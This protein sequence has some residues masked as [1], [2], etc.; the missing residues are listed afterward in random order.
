LWCANRSSHCC[1]NRAVDLSELLSW[2]SDDAVDVSVTNLGNVGASGDRS[3]TPMATATYQLSAKGPGGEATQTAT[4]NVGTQP[5]ATLAASQQEVHYYKI[6]NKVVQDDPITLNWSA[7]NADKVTITA[8][9]DQGTNG[10]ATVTSEPVQVTT[11]NVD[12]TVNYTLSASNACGGTITKTAA[13]HVVAFLK[14]HRSK[15]I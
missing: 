6:G 1:A 12:E 11:G 5:V 7:S 2:K 9:G 14:L 15:A 4:V 8:L 3:V 10:S 13:L